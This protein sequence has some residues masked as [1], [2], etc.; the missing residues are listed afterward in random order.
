MVNLSFPYYEAIFTQNPKWNYKSH[1]MLI[2]TILQ[3]YGFFIEY[4]GRL[5]FLRKLTH[6]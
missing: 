4:M 6:K 2:T 1:H 5:Y 3:L